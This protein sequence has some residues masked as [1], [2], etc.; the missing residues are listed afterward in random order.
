MSDLLDFAQ[1]LARTA[2]EILRQRYSQPREIHAKGWRDLYTD[3]DV[4]AQEAIVQLIKQR[5][6]RANY[7]RHLP[8]FS[9]SIALVEDGQPLAGVI[10]DP[11]R[12]N[13]FAAEVD[14]GVQ[15]NGQPIR[16]SSTHEIA[17]GIVGLDWG[18]GEEARTAALTWLHK[19]GTQCRTIRAVGSSALSLCYLAAGWLDVYYHGELYPWDGAA[20]QVI[21]QEAGAKLFNFKRQKWHYREATCL[22]CNPQLVDWA[23]ASLG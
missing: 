22:A 19:A 15:L 18:R 13:L 11:L 2:G 23:L 3:A 21:A 10:Y 5:D 6:S 9:T 20:G 16:V 14:R 7:V 12:D 17:E 8:A 1:L 4:A